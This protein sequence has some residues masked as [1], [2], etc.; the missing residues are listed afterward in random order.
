MWALHH[1]KYIPHCENYKTHNGKCTLDNGTCVPN[2][3]YIKDTRYIIKNIATPYDGSA[4]QIRQ[5]STA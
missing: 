4:N 5:S 2:E 3:R 1:A